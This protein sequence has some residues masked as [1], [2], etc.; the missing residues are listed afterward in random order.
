MA[1]TM[2]LPAG[3][4]AQGW[5]VKIRDRERVEPPHVTVMRGTR[6]WRIGL[7]DLAF[8]DGEPPPREVPR[9]LVECVQRE[10]L[11]LSG[12]WDRMYPENPVGGADE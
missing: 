6:K 10:R 9:E 12:V 2:T 8:L 3:L 1:Y 4:R 5:K 11:L 7:R